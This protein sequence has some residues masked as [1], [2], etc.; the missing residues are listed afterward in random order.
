MVS[1]TIVVAV[2]SVQMP[3]VS[4]TIGCIECWSAKVEVVTAWIASIDTEV[5]IAVV[6]V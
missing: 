4:A 6:P 5:P 2:M 1:A 3:C